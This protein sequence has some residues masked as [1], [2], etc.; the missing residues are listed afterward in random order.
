M[1]EEQAHWDRSSHPNGLFGCTPVS[2]S[3]EKVT[4]D[5]PW[6]GSG[7]T[8]AVPMEMVMVTAVTHLVWAVRQVLSDS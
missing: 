6:T 7:A 1:G 2:T 8:P 4:R 5:L 3:H